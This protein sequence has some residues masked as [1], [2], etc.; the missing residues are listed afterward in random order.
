MI[1]ATGTLPEE[2]HRTL[3]FQISGDNKCNAQKRPS[4]KRRFY[5]AKSYGV[6]PCGEET[7][8]WRTMPFL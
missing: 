6:V 2:G 3:G 4:K 5:M 1:Y 7:V 8:A